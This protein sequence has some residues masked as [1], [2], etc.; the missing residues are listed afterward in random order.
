MMNML[1]AGGMSILSDGRRPAD[2]DNP[3]G[4]FELEAVKGLAQDASWLRDAA[5]KA[6][7]VQAN[8]LTFLPPEF[9]YRVVFMHRDPEEIVASQEKVLSHRRPH[10]PRTPESSVGIIARHLDETLEW[11]SSQTQW[12]CVHVHYGRLVSNSLGDAHRINAFFGGQLE[13]D[14]MQG[15]VDSRL[16]RQRGRVPGWSAGSLM[17]QGD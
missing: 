3:L 15:V 16:Y 14:A 5:G 12:R 13:V 7:K 2:P 8:L 10:V 4:Y 1:Q 6:V 9:D 11:L 17:H